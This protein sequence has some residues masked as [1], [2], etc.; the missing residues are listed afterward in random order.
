MQCITSPTFDCSLLPGYLLLLIYSAANL[1]DRSWGTREQNSGADEG[2]WGWRVY[3]LKAWR[4]ITSSW[5]CVHCCFSRQ[6]KV[7][8]V[9]EGG[10]AVKGGGGGGVAKGKGEGGVAKGEG[11]GSVAEGRR[12]EGEDIRQSEDGGKGD[13]Q[14]EEKRDQEFTESSKW[15]EHTL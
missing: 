14:D 2:L 7:A 3:L 15:C 11:E 4:V 9:E 6:D 1:C 10:G 8:V 13:S 12:E 5:C